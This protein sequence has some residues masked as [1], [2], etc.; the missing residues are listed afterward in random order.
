ML[1]YNLLVKT[2]KKV[3]QVILITAIVVIALLLIW[4]IFES[5]RDDEFINPFITRPIP[6]TSLQ[7][8]K[9]AVASDIH[10]D[11]VYLEKA[12]IRA[13]ADG[14]EFIIIT[15]DL[16]SLGKKD[17]L[18]EIKNILDESSVKYYVIPGNHDL[19]F[20][21]KVK[22]D[23]F[24]EVFGSDYQSFKID[25]TKFILVNNGSWQG[26]TGQQMTWLKS[27]V[28]ECKVVYCLVFAHMPFNHGTSE[29]IMGEDNKK[30]SSQAAELVKLF[31]ES[32]VREVFVG[33]LHYATS[34]Q[35][36]GLRTNIVGA[37]TSTR[38]TQTP[39][40]L[41]MERTGEGLNK[42]EVVLD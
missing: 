5:G 13:K 42:K 23:V 3:V 35:L 26:M 24:G 7:S 2:F 9:F 15:G 22:A 19:W 21:E 11:D 10:L 1:C 18:V 31:V 28:A 36:D 16:T 20:S 8:F 33:H 29:H 25:D 6:T 4:R 37:I 39:R 14:A 40:F 32:N 12:L 17:E 34:Y 30:V 41:E 27:E 38:N